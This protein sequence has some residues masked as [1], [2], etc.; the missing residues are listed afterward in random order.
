MANYIGDN[1][2]KITFSATLILGGSLLFAYFRM[3]LP[4]LL[5]ALIAAA[6]SR[7]LIYKELAI[8]EFWRTPF[9]VVIAWAVGASV[10][11][12]AFAQILDSP[13]I[14]AILCCSALVGSTF[15]YVVFRYVGRFEKA[16]AFLACLPA[17]ITETFLIAERNQLNTSSVIVAHTVRLVSSVMVIPFILPTQ[18]GTQN[19]NMSL[20][21]IPSIAQFTVFTIAVLSVIIGRSIKLPAAVFLAPVIAVTCLALSP[22]SIDGPP[23]SWLIVSQI[24][25]GSMLGFEVAKAAQSSFRYFGLSVVASIITLAIVVAIA[26]SASSLLSLNFPFLLLATTPGGVSEMSLISLSLGISAGAI[27]SLHLLRIF[28]ILGLL[29]VIGSK[30]TYVENRK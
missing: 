4:W 20:E 2:F 1:I 15:S 10:S 3:P 22:I 9:I 26:F 28:I 7:A 19:I 25:I 23:S 29:S 12:G 5:G 18:S 14:I 27:I 17:G 21:I 11:R 16:D 30:L 13:L 24:I 6:I 8:S